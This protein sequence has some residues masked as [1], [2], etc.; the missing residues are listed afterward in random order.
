MHSTNNH[1]RPT[2]ISSE[3]F[4][5]IYVVPS[6]GTT[7]IPLKIAFASLVFNLSPELDFANARVVQSQRNK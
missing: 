5:K 1:D 7:G 2:K 6:T 4:K 3:N